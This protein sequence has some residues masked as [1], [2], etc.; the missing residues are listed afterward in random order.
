[1]KM[2]TNYK[3]NRAQQK[4]FT[5]L[6]ILS[7]F[8]IMGLLVMGV[9][10]LFS[11]AKSSGNSVEAIK[12]MIAIRS[13]VEGTYAGQG[14]YGLGEL[15]SVLITAR[16]VPSSMSVSG[17][18]ISTSWGGTL[19]VTG[20]GPN[21]RIAIT[22]VPTDMCSSL[23]SNFSSGFSAVQVGS[24]TPLTTFPVRPEVATA[25]AQCGGSPPFAITWTTTS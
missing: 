4:G 25:A 8:A 22:N 2:N 17:N 1:M 21:F 12:N 5:L 18:T 15:N 3:F 14:G 20:N 16:K 10:A 23:L 7:V 24:S 11:N 13:E 19:T 6:E 9:M